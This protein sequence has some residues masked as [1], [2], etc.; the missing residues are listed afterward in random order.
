MSHI[1]LRILRICPL[2]W[3]YTVTTA[4]FL[5]LFM[6]AYFWWFNNNKPMELYNVPFPMNK[7]VVAA[8]D[9]VRPFVSYCLNTE[10]G[11]T[12]R[13]FLVAND[14]PPRFF[15]LPVTVGASGPENIG[16]GEVWVM[17]FRISEEVQPGSYYIQGAFE[18]RV[19]ILRDRIVPFRTEPFEVVAAL[20]IQQ[21]R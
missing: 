5:L 18:F 9:T 20:P 10:I 7:Q 17:P 14:E 3:A 2:A 4:L 12:R 13:A 6:G 15:I 1:I 21:G 8:G 11:P 19:N 16:C